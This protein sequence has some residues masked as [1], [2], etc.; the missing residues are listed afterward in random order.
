MSQD[1]KVVVTDQVFP[2]IDT[3][4]QLLAAIGA[5]IEVADGTADGVAR[6][7]GDA[8]ALL[9]TYLPITDQ[10]LGQLPACKIVA[11]YGIGTDNVDLAAAARRGVVVTN[12]PDYSVEEVAVHALCLMLALTR[13]LPEASR[14][15]AGG[16]WGLDGLR[17]IRRLSTQRAGLVGFGRIARCLAGYLTA[18]GCGVVAH[19]PFLQPGPG[20]PPLLALPDL[21]SRCDVV[22]LHAPLT[23]R[24]RGLI[25]AA[26]LATMKPSAVLINTARGGLV[27]TDA[28]IEALRAGRIRAA[29][30]DVLDTEP[31]AAGQ[32]PRRPAGA[33]GDA[34]HGLLLRGVH[35]RITAE[36][37]DP[38]RQGP[39]R[40]PAR[41]PG[42]ALVIPGPAHEKG[43]QRMKEAFGGLSTDWKEG[44]N[45][46]AVR[47]WRLQRARE[48]M[49]R[50]GLGAL[51]LFYDE[52]MRYVSSTYT[53]GWNRLKP[54]LRY[55]VLCEGK[56]PIVYEQGDIGIHLKAHNPWIPPQNIRHSYTWIKGAAGPAAQNQVA[57]FTTA[58]VADLED[59][60]VLD[61]P[62]GVDFIDINM[63][64]AFQRAGVTW[65]DGMTPMMEARSIKSPDEQKASRIVGA[66]CDSL[67]YEFT[68]FLR[69]GLTENEVAAFGF[70][71]LYNIPG[72]E[73]VEDIIVSS[74]PNAWPNWRNFS[75][76]IIRPGELVIVDL[77]ALTWNGFKSC[78]YRTYCVGGKPTDEMRQYYDTA[79]QWLWDAIEVVRPGVT[80]RDI[81]SK[82]PSAKEAWGYEEEDQAAANLWGHGLGLA[83]Y[84][85]PVISRI[86]SLD[87][88][89][90]IKPGM[91][92]A[93][94]T[95]HG[96]VHEFGVRLE[97][98]LLVT[99]DGHEL[100]SSYASDQ[101]INAG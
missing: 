18:L 94:E 67:H 87:Y 62:L 88:P 63:I 98:M 60:G 65:V 30:L 53:P 23:A 6:L 81:A 32:A 93:L 9:N 66:I 36:G 46:A 69:P 42:A 57:K 89:E 34:A 100:L 84:D 13:R 3:E 31:P 22:S 92:F 90:E 77:A 86:W 24:T 59:A 75:D 45:W 38:D 39:D 97:E 11:R 56:E 76:R 78:V 70:E 17:P 96:K 71:Y 14:L 21:L 28:V 52:N 72:M 83:Q 49:A 4:T 43:R 40:R 54:G 58:L 95:Q 101:I 55:V 99:D 26:E 64:A 8:D 20:L 15:V 37:G 91:V 41:L 74:G 44:I 47:A 35:R 85:R 29:A 10:L 48:A 82:W 33:A 19:D 73:D 7:G 25:G 27:D 68:Q 61:K 79:H 51:L 12:V 1:F 80:T 16:G 2:S 5:R 50:H